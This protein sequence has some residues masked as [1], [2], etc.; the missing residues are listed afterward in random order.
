MRFMRNTQKEWEQ[1][2]L[3]ALLEKSLQRNHLAR[4]Q[5]RGQHISYATQISDKLPTFVFFVSNVRG[6]HFSYEHYL[7][8]QIRENFGFE[9]VPLKIVFRE[10]R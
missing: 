8:N 9:Q 5:G 10:K 1:R 6:I 7:S 2:P 4:F 3:N